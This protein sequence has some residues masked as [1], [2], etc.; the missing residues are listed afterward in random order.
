MPAPSRGV[1][2]YRTA[3]MWILYLC[4]LFCLGLTMGRTATQVSL[5]IYSFLFGYFK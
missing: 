2:V 4:A 5:C 3:E 1:G